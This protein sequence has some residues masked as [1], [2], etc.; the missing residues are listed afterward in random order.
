M[1]LIEMRALLAAFASTALRSQPPPI[2]T[3][4]AGGAPRVDGDPAFYSV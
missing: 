1:K 4:P 2:S 3:V